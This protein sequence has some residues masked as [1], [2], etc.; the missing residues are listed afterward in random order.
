MKDLHIHTKYSDGEFDEFE[1]IEKILKSNVKEFAICDHDTIEGS[2]RVFNELSKNNHGLVFH[3]G[4]ELTCRLNEFENGVNMHLLF[5]DFEYSNQNLEKII[6]KISYLRHIK[7]DRMVKYVEDVYNIKIP[8]DMLMEKIKST[9]SFGK[10]HLYSIMCEIGDFDRE[11]YYRIMDKLDVSDLKLSSNE[12]IQILKDSGKIFLAHPVEIMKEYNYD[13][14]K[15][16]QLIKY[17]K[18]LGITGVE[19]YHSEQ[20]INLQQQLSQI[21]KKYNLEESQGSDYHGP[22]VKPK[23][24]I[25]DIYKK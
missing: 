10:P 7:I 23:L 14:E 20:N 6:D 5:R 9:K 12:T 17:L 19:T 24:N 13:I 18:D 15:I 21:A 8:T 16:E 2:Q 22:N 4:V 1:I 11:Q 3:S 25:G